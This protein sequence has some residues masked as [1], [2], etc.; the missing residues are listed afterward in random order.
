MAKKNVK[1]LNEELEFMIKSVKF[2]NPGI[3]EEILRAFE[4]CDR[5]FFIREKGAK[6][7]ADLPQHI[8]HGQTISQP[9]TIAR[10]IRLLKL[11][12]GLDVLEI[13]A[14]TG[15]HASLVAWL[16]WPGK[17]MTIEIF[18]DLAEMARKNIKALIKHLEKN[19]KKEAKKF[20][21]ITVVTGDALDPKTEI[22]KYKY[23]RIYFTAG[24][25]SDKISEVKKM[26]EK[27]LKD[28]G[29]LLYPTRE[30]YDFGALEAWQLHNGK[31]KLIL[32]ETGYAFVPLL[33]K[34]EFEEIYKKR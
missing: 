29:V 19:N 14:N 31:L 25:E 16:V 10:M 33:K 13:G 18:P 12:E 20:S 21:K 3:N 23:D 2:N 22:W 32:R 30:A 7:Y 8:A 9:S 24:V 11:E 15:Y 5:K 28:D 26:G 27:L 1:K 6:V 4:I 17:V 34:E